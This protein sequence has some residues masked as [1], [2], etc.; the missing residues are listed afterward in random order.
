MLALRLLVCIVAAK[1]T[2]SVFKAHRAN[3][4]VPKPAEELQEAAQPI[5][6]TQLVSVPTNTLEINDQ[7]D[8]ILI[9]PPIEC[10]PP[11]LSTN[12]SVPA[13]SS[14]LDPTAAPFYPSGSHSGIPATRVTD[15]ERLGL[16]N[17]AGLSNAAYERNVAALLAAGNKLPHPEL[18]TANRRLMR[19]L[20]AGRYSAMRR[21][22][23]KNHN[24]ET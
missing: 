4:S 6:Q 8:V 16:F 10:T 13:S 14:A 3:R 1:A 18:V 23:R 11:T 7:G 19:A 5:G 20:P 9:S 21:W 12:A 15:D 17:G 22:K 2:S 24:G